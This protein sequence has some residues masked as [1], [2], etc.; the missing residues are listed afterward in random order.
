[1]CQRLPKLTNRQTHTVTPA[2]WAKEQEQ[3]KESSLKLAS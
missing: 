2:A 3:I 1:M